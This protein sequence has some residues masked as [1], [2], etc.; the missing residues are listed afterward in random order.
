MCR[1]WRPRKNFENTL[2]F[3]NTGAL[4]IRIGFGGPS[5]YDFKKEPPKIVTGIYLGPILIEGSSP[6]VVVSLVWPRLRD[7]FLAQGLGFGI[8]GSA[9]MSFRAL[10][11]WGAAFGTRPPG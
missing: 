5:Y 8:L 1:W 10:G 9:F 3:G 6:E 11:F 2:Q 7:N 4:I